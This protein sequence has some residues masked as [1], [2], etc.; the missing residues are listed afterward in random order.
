MVKTILEQAFGT[1][2]KAILDKTKA[3]QIVACGTSYHAGMVA[4][5]WI[6]GIAGIP[7][8]VEVASEFRYRK[9]VVQE[10]TLLSP[11]H[12]QVKP[13]TSTGRVAASQNAGLCINNDYL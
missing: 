7:C 6:E 8:R 11:F 5:Y 13:L 3:V 12:S 10:D 1:E 2:A 9:F 4:Q